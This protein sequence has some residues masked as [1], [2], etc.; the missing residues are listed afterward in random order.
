MFGR[1][2]GTR[3]IKSVDT[4]PTS[5]YVYSR[6]HIKVMV[7]PCSIVVLLCEP[8]SK[9]RVTFYYGGLVYIISTV[10]ERAKYLH[11]YNSCVACRMSNAV[12]LVIC[13]RAKVSLPDG[14]CTMLIV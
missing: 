13:L 2:L 10:S 5:F 6:D 9:K 11:V 1:G 14:P 7:H 3:L 8:F 4:L 12:Y